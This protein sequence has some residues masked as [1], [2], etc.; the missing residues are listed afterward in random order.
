MYLAI[1]H[2][3]RDFIGP[4]LAGV[5]F[6][7]EGVS[8]A[9][10]GPAQ[11]R[12]RLYSCALRPRHSVCLP[13]RL[14][15]VMDVAALRRVY[16]ATSGFDKRSAPAEHSGAGR[17]RERER[18]REE[19]R[20]L[21]SAGDTRHVPSHAA[22]SRRERLP[23]PRWTFHFRPPDNGRISFDSRRR[24]ERRRVTVHETGAAENNFRSTT[25]SC[26]PR[27]VMQL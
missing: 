7:L 19:K 4:H 6:Q 16:R 12:Q 17:E 24:M 26:H 18:E 3:R 13:S 23:S 11:F 15:A 14:F 27:A 10:S 2:S 21:L 5:Q 8:C 1:R 20:A 9:Q 22:N 25:P